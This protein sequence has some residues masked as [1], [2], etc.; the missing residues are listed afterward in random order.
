MTE[1][2]TEVPRVA[3]TWDKQRKYDLCFK[4]TEFRD[5]REQ[6]T[7]GKTLSNQNPSGKRQSSLCHFTTRCHRISYINSYVCGASWRLNPNISLSEIPNAIQIIQYMTLFPKPITIVILITVFCTRCLE[8]SA[9]DNFQ[10][11]VTLGS[12]KNCLRHLEA[13]NC[14]TCLL[15]HRGDVT[16]GVYLPV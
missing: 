4:G 12:F 6:H 9:E 11:L 14:H 2:I 10:E 15:R 7:R 13:G 1:I 16:A 8:L 3:D 5:F